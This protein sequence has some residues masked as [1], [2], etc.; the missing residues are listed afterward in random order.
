METKHP[1]WGAITKPMIGYVPFPVPW[2]GIDILLLTAPLHFIVLPQPSLITSCFTEP[3]VHPPAPPSYYSPPFLLFFLSLYLQ[4]VR[5]FCHTVC[6]E[7]WNLDTRA[8]SRPH[9]LHRKLA[10]VSTRGR[11][12]LFCVRAHHGGE[13]EQR[14][15]RSAHS[16]PRRSL[17]A[18]CFIRPADICGFISTIMKTVS[19]TWPFSPSFVCRV[20]PTAAVVAPANTW[21]GC[22][23]LNYTWFN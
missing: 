4:P 16:R 6:A 14:A 22:K 19:A 7:V 18:V 8:G 10:G 2:T 12:C 3:H 20:L 11:R 15:G 9:P 13:A 5:G 23:A 1:F 17:L 21:W